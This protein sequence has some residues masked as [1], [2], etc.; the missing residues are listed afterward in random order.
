MSHPM[1]KVS[2]CKARADSQPY[3]RFSRAHSSFWQTKAIPVVPFG[4]ENHI[5]SVSTRADIVSFTGWSFSLTSF[6]INFQVL[7]PFPF[8][9]FYILLMEMIDNPNLIYAIL[10]GSDRLH[11]LATFTLSTALAEIARAKTA[12]EEHLRRTGAVTPDQKRAG[13]P[14]PAPHS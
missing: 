11:A 9:A 13:S 5:R 3:S 7:F 1:S 2:A 12:K 8:N 6:T 14:Q 4:C 10:R